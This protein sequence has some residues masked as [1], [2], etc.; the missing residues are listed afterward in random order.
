MAFAS[1]ESPIIVP[2]PWASTIETICGGILSKLESAEL[3][4]LI[5]DILLGAINPSTLLFFLMHSDCGKITIAAT[6]SPIPKPS[7]D[8]SNDLHLPSLESIID[9]ENI[10][11][12]V[13]FNIS[14]TPPTIAPT[15]CCLSIFC[16]ATLIDTKED[17]HAVSIVKEGPVNPNEYEIRFD[18]KEEE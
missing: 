13:L 6:A 16:I 7:A 15:H 17:E 9:F 12:V 4:Q 1:I 11:K 3:I 8:E 5:W 10:T 2:V 18:I 14:C